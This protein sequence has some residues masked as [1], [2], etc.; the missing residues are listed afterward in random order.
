MLNPSKNAN[1]PPPPA[2]HQWKDFKHAQEA[3]WLAMWKENVNSNYKYVMLAA[4][5][6]VRGQS[7][8]KKFETTR[9]LKQ[10]ID[11]IRYDYQRGLRHEIMEMRQLATAMY[12]I[13]K[14]ALRA[15]NGKGEGEADTVGCCF[16]K[17]ENLTLKPPDTVVLDFLGKETIRFYDEVAV[18]RQVFKD[19]KIFKKSLKKEG[20]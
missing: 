17:F 5:S 16:L 1:M 12:L 3:T 15:G 18:D 7:D 9:R 10:H 19:F 2:G 11:R 13:D 4:N 14:L 8:Y 6:D 20:N